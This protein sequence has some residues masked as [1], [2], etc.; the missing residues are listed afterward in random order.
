MMINLGEPISLKEVSTPR[1]PLKPWISMQLA[2]LT[3]PPSEHLRGKV[4]EVLESFD[5][6][7][8][9]QIDIDEFTAAICMEADM[10]TT[11]V[12]ADAVKKPGQTPV[13]S[14]ANIVNES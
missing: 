8:D 2:L 7:G 6:D 4:N 5:K 3:S 13:V 10:G 12:A 1:G 11:A 9:G 14:L